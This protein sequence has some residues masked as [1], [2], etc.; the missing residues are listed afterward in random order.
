MVQASSGLAV[1]WN[2]AGRGAQLAGGRVRENP[3]LTIWRLLQAKAQ[4]RNG[5]DISWPKC[6]V[7][8]ALFIDSDSVGAAKVTYHH[9]AV[10]VRQ[11]AM[12]AGDSK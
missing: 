12:M 1:E 11:D 9:L 3:R 2:L 10:L 8:D 4:V 5:Q 7:F 6:S